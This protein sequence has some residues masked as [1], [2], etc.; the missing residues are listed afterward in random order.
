MAKGEREAIS[1]ASDPAFVNLCQLVKRQIDI[2]ETATLLRKKLKTELLPT[3]APEA[4]LDFTSCTKLFEYRL[5]LL[6]NYSKLQATPFYFKHPS[7]QYMSNL[8][9]PDSGADITIWGAPYKAPEQ[10]MVFWRARLFGDEE[11][12]EQAMLETNPL[13]WPMMSN[14]VKHKAG[15][16]LDL[17]T[18]L[19]LELLMEA[20]W[21]KFRQ[22]EDIRQRLLKE[23][24]PLVESN[25]RPSQWNCGLQ[26]TNPGIND[27]AS[28]ASGC[29][30]LTG[31][32]LDYIKC[33]LNSSEFNFD[34]NVNSNLND[35]TSSDNSS[36]TVVEKQSVSEDLDGLCASIGLKRKGAGSKT[37]ES[38]PSKMENIRDK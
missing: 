9:G 17:W 11:T 2:G 20:N 29:Y 21:A 4:F 30:N 34:F 38:P 22:H 23:K 24:S 5:T 13:K 19:T 37:S 12:A 33:E 15:V 35:L 1:Y 26:D 36:S 3:E 14:K 10:F 6:D 16:S 8:A 7:N 18:M 27:Q 31:W 25:L 28:W 32:M